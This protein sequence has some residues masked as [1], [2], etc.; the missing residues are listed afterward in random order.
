MHNNE[1]MGQWADKVLNSFDGGA[2]AKPQPFLFTRLRARMERQADTGWEK[3]VRLLGRP[4]VAIAGLCL[5]LAINLGTVFASPD[6]RTG[7]ELTVAPDELSGTVTVL[8]DIDNN[9]P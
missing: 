7:E 5:L 8:Y 9:E 3:A 2:R 6:E 4:A 1:Q